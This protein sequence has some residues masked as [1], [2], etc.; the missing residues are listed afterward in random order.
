MGFIANKNST[1]KQIRG[2]YRDYMTKASIIALYNAQ[3][4][5]TIT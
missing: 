4:S 1:T 2:E 3:L 5:V